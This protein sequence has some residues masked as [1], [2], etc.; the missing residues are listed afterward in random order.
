M[1]AEKINRADLETLSFTDLCKLADDYGIDVPENLN[2][3]FLIAE[4]LELAEE[5][6][7]SGDNMV[8]SSDEKFGKEKHFPQNYNETE[9]S[10]VLRN[11][12]WLFVFWN[13][14]EN[15]EKMIKKIPGCSLMLRICTMPNAKDAM[16]DEAFEIAAATESQEQYVLIPPGKKYIKVELVYEA[17]NTGKVL[18]ISPLITIPQGSSYVNDLQMGRD[19]EFPEII[20]LSGM[21]KILTDQY[22]NYRHSFS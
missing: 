12:A 22:K 18:A 14:S 17:G 1:K 11:P 9:I 4:L 8:I 19:T 5:T 15:D 2:R 10:C 21:N 6:E 3:R 20:Q 13:I 7:I 16:P